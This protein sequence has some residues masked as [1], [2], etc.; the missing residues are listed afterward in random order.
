MVVEVHTRALVESAVARDQAKVRL[1]LRSWHNLLRLRNLHRLGSETVPVSEEQDTL[2]I[3]LVR[4]LYP[5]A[6]PGN[7]PHGL[8]EP[9]RSV[10]GV[11]AIVLAHDGFDSLSSFIGI[12][13]GDGRDVVMQHVCFD[14]AMEKLAAD[15]SELAVNGGGSSACEVP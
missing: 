7:L 13:E 1:L 4:R 3:G 10:F 11:A 2:A 9:D 12:V 6:P 8:D 14:D 15:E 5:L